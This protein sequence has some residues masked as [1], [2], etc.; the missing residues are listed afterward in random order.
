[1]NLVN[2]GHTADHDTAGANR[3]SVGDQQEVFIGSV[4]DVQTGSA[5]V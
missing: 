2:I 1:M 5:E 4:A 3:G